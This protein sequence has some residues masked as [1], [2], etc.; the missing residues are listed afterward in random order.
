M[1]QERERRNLMSAISPCETRILPS[2]HVGDLAASLLHVSIP[3]L[4]SLSLRKRHDEAAH[5][6]QT[7]SCRPSTVGTPTKT[8]EYKILEHTD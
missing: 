6:I 7:H 4:V 3:C 5:A 2:R 8:T 1:S